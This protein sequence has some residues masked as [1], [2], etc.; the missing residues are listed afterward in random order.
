MIENNWIVYATLFLLGMGSGLAYIRF[1]WISVKKIFGNPQSPFLP[2]F[3]FFIRLGSIGF[4]LFFI[5]QWF[6]F[7]G[8]LFYLAG[9]FIT[10][11]I[12]QKKYYEYHS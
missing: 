10:K 4:T 5:A 3:G 1:L 8:V 6:H 9:F 7:L 11:K 2:I 12:G